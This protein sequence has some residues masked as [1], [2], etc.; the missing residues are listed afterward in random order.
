MSSNFC[1]TV[2]LPHG[3]F[4]V[5]C[6]YYI[7]GH[8][9]YLDRYPD[10][11]GSKTGNKRRIPLWLRA[12]QLQ[13][14]PNQGNDTSSS[15]EPWW[16]EEWLHGV[17]DENLGDYPIICRVEQTHA[18]FPPDPFCKVVR[19]DQKSDS[20]TVYFKKPKAFQGICKTNVRLAVTL[21]P[22]TPLLAPSLQELESM[23]ASSL[24]LPPT[25]TAVTFPCD[26]EPFI[27]P[28]AWC[29]TNS[30][31]LSPNLS[32]SVYSEESREVRISKFS[33]LWNRDTMQLD[34]RK[35]F[36]ERLLSL[37]R[38]ELEKL[39]WKERL[40]LPA[41]DFRIVLDTWYHLYEQSP[42]TQSGNAGDGSSTDRSILFSFLLRSTLPLWNSVTVMK[43][44]NERSKR[45]IS[46][47]L[48]AAKQGHIDVVSPWILGDSDEHFCLDESLRMK[49]ECAVEDVVALDADLKEMFFDPVTEECAPSYFCA[50]PVGICF[51][52]IL[53]RIKVHPG[54]K[55]CYYRSADAM[56]ADV[57]SVL[58]CC[59]LYNSP[60]SEVVN[61]A[62]SVVTYAKDV[63][64]KVAQDHYRTAR[65]T[66]SNQ[67]DHRLLVL[68]QCQPR[69]LFVNQGRKAC[70]GTIHRNWLDLKSSG[71]RTIGLTNGETATSDVMHSPFQAGDRILYC[72]DLHRRFVDGHTSSLQP[73]QCILPLPKNIGMETTNSGKSSCEDWVLG[74]VI[75]THSSFPNMAESE[76]T[77][78]FKS[79]AVLQTVV[80]KFRQCNDVCVLFWRPCLFSFDIC[81]TGSCCPGCGLSSS[82]VRCC[83]QSYL[84]DEGIS[85]QVSVNADQLRSMYRCITLLKR[86]CLRSMDPASVDPLL[87]KENVKS[88]Y[89]TPASK[90]GK[91]FLRTSEYFLCTS[92]ESAEN[93]APSIQHGTRG[94]KVKQK[95]EDDVDVQLLVNSGF[96]PSWRNGLSS[97]KPKELL[98]KFDFI[99]PAPQQ[100]LEFVIVKLQ[101]GFYRHKVAIE[102]DIVEAYVSNIVS[103]LYDKATRNMSPISIKRIAQFVLNDQDISLNPNISKEEILL[104]KRIRSIRRLYA[105]ALVSVTDSNRSERIFGLSTPAPPKRILDVNAERDQNR[106]LAR[107][108]LMYLVTVFGRD[109]CLNVFGKPD[110]YVFGCLPRF[111]VILKYSCENGS[112]SSLMATVN[113]TCVRVNIVCGGY[114]VLKRDP[115][116]ERHHVLKR[117]DAFNFSQLFCFDPEDYEKNEE[118]SHLF[119]SRPSRANSCVRCQAQRRPMLSC[120]VLRR[121]SNPDFDWAPFAFGGTSFVDDLIMAL[122]P[123]A[124][125]LLDSLLVNNSDSDPIPQLNVQIE[126]HPKTSTDIVTFDE[127]CEVDP[128]PCAEQGAAAVSL[129][130]RVFAAAELFSEAPLRLS[131]AFIERSFPVDNSDGHYLYCVVCGLSGDLLCCD[132]CPNVVHSGC[133]SLEVLPDG[134]WFCEECLGKRTTTLESTHKQDS[135]AGTPENVKEPPS[136]CRCEVF[137]RTL[138]DDS[139]LD[140]LMSQIDSLRAARPTHKLKP[141]D[142]DETVAD[143]DD[144]VVFIREEIKEDAETSVGPKT[145]G[146][147]RIQ[148]KVAPLPL[149]KAPVDES[150]HSKRQK[151]SAL[152]RGNSSDLQP[153]SATTHHNSLSQLRTLKVGARIT[154][155]EISVP[156]SQRGLAIADTNVPMLIK[157]KS[158]KRSFSARMSSLDQGMDLQ[159][160]QSKR[161]RFRT[162]RLVDSR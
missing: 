81:T 145:R 45:K 131:K 2:I 12:A 117:E 64:A 14:K 57:R 158:R 77:S 95:K 144:G 146:R 54:H 122:S 152:Q 161:T 113:S 47:W 97:Q 71:D 90:I 37:G 39:L 141:A 99:F 98:K 53:K 7:S 126:T 69:S 80:V 94:V 127:D 40:A 9:A 5:L 88:G 63:L 123:T 26:L 72:R 108:Q 121:H 115:R 132:G 17:M 143:C 134:D 138:F 56:I 82:F 149:D 102:N 87:T 61:E 125:G 93:G 46:P 120:R 78:S 41:Q 109:M 38:N 74:E 11:L 65:T 55:T 101:S 86:R 28:F 119:F 68:G 48:L 140:F 21:R 84:E 92:E 104:I 73:G 16:T 30:H 139:V 43:K 136:I 106:E 8:M 130:T 147:P 24:Q 96:L 31:H 133:I 18:E 1:G 50:V 85:K 25:F 23:K 32:V 13:R 29:Y 151:K 52:I 128:R 51:S 49:L 160:R 114:S 112:P 142:L 22:L 76:A 100:C 58:A 19:T 105:T 10:H 6:R 33:T 155:V 83:D 103:L 129:A 59:L 124:A 157:A 35:M 116:A 36:I 118:L 107:Q 135:L 66:R 67:N 42:L 20:T 148:S 162:A 156:R 27:V 111:N 70:K 89:K 110:N 15:I 79:M 154:E 60:D 44:R 150:N 159:V 137:G 34:G 153:S 4:C 3:S 62:D 91:A 75:W